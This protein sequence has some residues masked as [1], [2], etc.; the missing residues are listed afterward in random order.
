MDV[1]LNQVEVVMSHSGT[2]GLKFTKVDYSSKE[3]TF[4]MTRYK[5]AKLY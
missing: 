3:V 4:I 5:N 1:Q 2:S